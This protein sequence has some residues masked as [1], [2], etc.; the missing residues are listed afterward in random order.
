MESVLQAEYALLCIADAFKAEFD[1]NVKMNKVG[2]VPSTLSLHFQRLSTSKSR[3]RCV[4]FYFNFKD[5]IF[6]ELVPPASGCCRLPHRH[7][8]ATP[9]LPCG[10]SDPPIDKYTGNGS[11]GPA[12]N[13]LTKAIHAFVHFTLTASQN[14]LLLCDLQGQC[15]VQLFFELF[16]VFILGTLDFKGV[17]C[18]ID[19]QAHT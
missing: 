16:D 19:P 8:I 10:P 1:S 7:F 15:Y 18:L 4:G 17:P 11:V 2:N 13:D 9:L 3:F 6:G 14:S 5:S 12:N